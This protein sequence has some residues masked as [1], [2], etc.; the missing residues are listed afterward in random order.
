MA[1][2]VLCLVHLGRR[3][4]Q[5]DRHVAEILSATER[6]SQ[7]GDA[8][9]HALLDPANRPSPWNLAPWDTINHSG[10]AR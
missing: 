9:P 1:L 8:H 10:R 3:L 7:V 2:F 4:E 5:V 6:V